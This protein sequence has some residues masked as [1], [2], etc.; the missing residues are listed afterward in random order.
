VI[1][2]LAPAWWSS[3]VNLTDKLKGKNSTD[4]VK[5]MPRL[6]GALVV[7]EVTM[8]AAVLVSA[9]LLVNMLAQLQS[10]PLGFAPDNVFTMQISLPGSK[11]SDRLGMH[12]LV[13]MARTTGKPETFATAFRA[14]VGQIDSEQPVYNVRT[15][16]EIIARATS[17]QRFQALLSSIFATIALLLVAVGIYSVVTYTVRQRRREIGVRLAV[18]ASRQKILTMV[19]VQGLRNVLLGLAL[20]LAASLAIT[21]VIG[22]TVFGPTDVRIYIFSAVLLLGVAFIACYLPARRATRIDPWLALRNE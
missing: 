22:S 6:R 5:G 12:G 19:I 11:Y 15:M 10:V 18:G 17:Q 20:G 7:A 16:N 1:F 9:G 14:E 13:V 8:A 4:G 21:R 2:G 3:R